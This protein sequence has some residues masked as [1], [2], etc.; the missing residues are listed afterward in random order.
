[1]RGQL[2]LCLV[3]AGDL[4]LGIGA[5]EEEGDAAFSAGDF[6]GGGL[7]LICLYYRPAFSVSAQC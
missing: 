1:M 7:E 4:G 2:G 6:F 5:E 3:R